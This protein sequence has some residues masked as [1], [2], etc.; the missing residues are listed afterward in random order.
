LLRA[1]RALEALT[2]FEQA[3]ALRPEDPLVAAQYALL[4]SQERGLTVR[5]LE[6]ARGALVRGDGDP[7]V[8]ELVARVL[9]S[10]GAREEALEMLRTAQA[11]FSQHPGLAAL[12]ATLCP[13]RAPTFP[14]L[15]RCHPLNKYVGLLTWRLGLRGAAAT[16]AR[17]LD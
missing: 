13:R 17:A 11:R 15:P 4:L 6:L 16:A 1:R 2:C 14:K 3:F 7:Q 10:T 5:A 8:Q 12:L 9:L